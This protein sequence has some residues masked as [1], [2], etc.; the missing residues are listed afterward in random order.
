MQIR[1]LYIS[2]M[3]R[4]GV[5]FGI[6][7]ITRAVRQAG[8]RP[9]L[10]RLPESYNF[11]PGLIPHSLPPGWWQG[12]DLVQGRSRVAFSLK[13]TGLPVVTT[14]HHL[15]TDPDL[16]PYSS[17]AQR[18]FYR[19]VE[20]RYDG[21]SV[22]YAD[23]VVCVSR[24]TQRQVEQTYGRADSLL[25]FDGI[26]TAVFT[27]TPGL[28]RRDDGVPVAPGRI[29]LL[30]VGN[31]TRRKGFDLLPQIMDRLPDDYV[32]Y[33]TGGFQGRETKPP[34]ARMVPI[35]SP[36]R[37]G[38]VAAYQSCDILLFPSRLEGFGIAPAEAL[39]CGRPVVTTNAGALPEVVDEGQSGFL[40]A[41]DNVAAYAE[42]VRILGEDAALRRRFAEFGRE[43]VVAQFGYEQLGEGFRALYARLLGL[44]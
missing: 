2:P 33:Y 12:F 44:G 36:D 14:V 26:D 4:G 5:D 23:A 19:L 6:Q 9:E 28:V 35:G 42:K 38:L 31:R 13:A 30:F 11:L 22:A 18:L 25:I 1:P 8:L 16:Q 32:L 34:H 17:L 10:L 40:V 20:A 7:N 41:R 24:F 15:T 29:R 3:G 43:K 39:A 37:A 27:P 21:L